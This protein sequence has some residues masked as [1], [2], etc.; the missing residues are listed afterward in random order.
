LKFGVEVHDR[1]RQLA[2]ADAR[3]RAIAE[4]LV[5]ALDA[6]N[7]HNRTLM[8]LHALCLTPASVAPPALAAL[9]ARGEAL[10][11]Q[12]EIAWQ[13]AQLVARAS[14]LEG[15][16]AWHDRPRL[17]GPCSLPGL[18]PLTALG[19]NEIMNFRSRHAGF[20]AVERV[21]YGRV[22]WTFHRADVLPLAEGAP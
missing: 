22:A 3:A 6:V 5:P 16:F 19:G 18:R 1:I 20:H 9:R 7:A 21:P 10:R 12:Q 14:Q 8:E 2:A 11:I 15:T 17:P 13:R 4:R